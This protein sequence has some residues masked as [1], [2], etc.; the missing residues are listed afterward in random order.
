MSKKPWAPPQKGT[1]LFPVVGQTPIRLLVKGVP[2]GSA[3]EA[4]LVDAHQGVLSQFISKQR[5]AYSLST[6]PIH[7]GRIERGGVSM[8]YMNQH[9]M[10]TAT[11]EVRPTS[12]GKVEPRKPKGYIPPKWVVIELDCLEIYSAQ[13]YFLSHVLPNAPPPTV[14]GT[15]VLPRPDMSGVHDYFRTAATGG[16]EHS[17]GYWDAAFDVVELAQPC[18]LTGS[19]LLDLRPFAAY[20]A[21]TVELY[22]YLR[23]YPINKLLASGPAVYAGTQEV[24][25]HGTIL[26]ANQGTTSGNWVDEDDPFD[27]APH[28]ILPVA[29]YARHPS[30][31]GLKVWLDD[32]SSSFPS[33]AEPLYVWTGSALVMSGDTFNRLPVSLG[34]DV[35]DNSY[36][37]IPDYWEE[38]GPV[39]EEGTKLCNVNAMLFDFEEPA[40]KGMPYHMDVP[41]PLTPQTTTHFGRW[42]IP[43]TPFTPKLVR[44]IS[45]Q[46]TDDL[47]DV[48]GTTY[49]L[50]PYLGPILVDMEH[51]G[52][53]LQT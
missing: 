28:S 40:W 13:G 26:R 11:L 35:V 23:A 8:T 51:R 27:P 6:I 4:R 52:V 16:Y 38:Y 49:P 19:L 18:T 5:H 29:W 15:V 20:K 47:P 10:E 41:S 44:Q 43:G 42:V 50:M 7:K 36:V 39:V 22:G 12:G 48:T 3:Q 32:G 34:G 30:Y 53:T 25:G 1:E 9:G 14:A 46:Q 45:I 21:V 24:T 33:G 2:P 17:W 31:T 37:A